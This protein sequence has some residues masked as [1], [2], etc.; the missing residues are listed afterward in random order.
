MKNLFRLALATLVFSIVACQ[1]QK[2]ENAPMPPPVA[3]AYKIPLDSL[4]KQAVALGAIFGDPATKSRS[5]TAANAIA[6]NTVLGTKHMTKSYNTDPDSPQ[7]YV[8]NFSDDQGF[9]ILVDDKRVGNNIL[10]YSQSGNIDQSTDNPGVLI[11]MDQATEY[12]SLLGFD[13]IHIPENYSP[14][15]SVRPSNWGRTTSAR[16]NWIYPLS[17]TASEI[18]RKKLID[19]AFGQGYP[20]SNAIPQNYPTGCTATA[21]VTIMSYYRW[22]ASVGSHSINWNDAILGAFYAESA[23]LHHLMYDVG[24]RLGTQYGYPSAG[25][26]S[27]SSDAVPG[28]F[29]AYGYSSGE[30]EGYNTNLALSEINSNKPIYVSGKVAGKSVGHA[31]V[32]DGYKT[33]RSSSLSVTDYVDDSNVSNP[34]LVGQKVTNRTSDTDYFHCNWGWDG[35]NN[36]YFY[37]FNT[38]SPQTFDNPSSDN[39]Q[40]YNYTEIL[41]MVRNIQH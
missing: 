23:N 16:C 29:R 33:V 1:K 31:W 12:L 14:N 3:K 19:A 15:T 20:Y 26:S 34:I 30:V 41:K 21:V 13:P 32:V 35:A 25:E 10:A 9:A 38:G 5:V 36:G 6:V 24:V 7:A 39:N 37:A 4:K 17:G 28:T 2:I 40:K 22:P 11:F 18:A 27:A 8:I